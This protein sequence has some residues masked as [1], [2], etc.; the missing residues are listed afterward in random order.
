MIILTKEM[1]KQFGMSVE[2]AE[3]DIQ[4][5]TPEEFLGSDEDE[6]VSLKKGDNKHP[7]DISPDDY[8]ENRTYV[9]KF[10]DSLPASKREEFYRVIFRSGLREDDYLWTVL[11][12]MG[13]I[14]MMYED[15]PGAIEDAAFRIQEHTDILDEKFKQVI[16]FEGS[17]LKFELSR[18][19]KD[20]ETSQSKIIEQY[21][22]LMVKNNEIFKNINKSMD[23]IIEDKK[24]Q[25]TNTFVESIKKD[26]PEI[27]NQH[28]VKIQKERDGRWF[29]RTNLVVLF[30][31]TTLGAL[32]SLVLPLLLKQL[33]L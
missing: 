7:L 32:V 31:G 30:V 8:L 1:E 26:F 25:I 11:H 24:L 3:E 27:V 4:D 5:N 20:F 22:V 12:I 28:L 2:D 10:I 21:K 6:A 15:I 19:I 13:Y 18:Q 9:E 16:E 17:R 29:T 23:K 33:G 14:K